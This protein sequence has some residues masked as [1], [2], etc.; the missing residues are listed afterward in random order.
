MTARTAAIVVLM[1]A[2]VILVPVTRA[3]SPAKDELPVSPTTSSVVP[4]AR[5]QTLSAA[6]A[7]ISEAK[8]DKTRTDLFYK[9]LER[10]ER[11]SLRL[12]SRAEGA[13]LA[14]FCADLMERDSCERIRWRAADFLA[15]YP[16]PVAADALL[17]V[18]KRSGSDDSLTR[19]SVCAALVSL[20]DQHVL[21]LLLEDLEVR[22]SP[23]SKAAGDE[24]R[25]NGR[26]LR[27]L[28]DLGDREA[29]APLSRWTKKKHLNS[30]SR[31]QLLQAIRDLRLAAD[32]RIIN[33]FN[34]GDDATATLR[35]NGFVIC[36]AQKNEM[37]EFYDQDYP[38][39]TSD[40]MFHT[41]MILAGATLDELEDLVLI[42]RTAEFVRAAKSACLAQAHAFQDLHLASLA[43]RNAAFLDVPA[44]LLGMAD[45][46]AGDLPQALREDVREE[47]RRIRAHQGQ[48]TSRIFPYVE[49][50]TK[51]SAR[52]RRG[53]SAAWEGYFQAMLYLGRMRYRLSEEEE[54]RQAFLLADAI[55]Q[56]KVLMQEWTD[57]DATLGAFF[58]PHDDLTPPDYLA[59][60]AAVG[61]PAVVGGGP[62]LR[63]LVRNPEMLAAAVDELRRRPAP[64]VNSAFVGSVEAAQTWKVR[65]AGMRVFGQRYTRPIH[66]LQEAVDAG[67]W[68]P[69]GLLVAA[70]LIG[71][72]RARDLLAKGGVRP[73]SR[74]SIPPAV[75][76]DS[77]LTEGMIRCCAALFKPD[78][79]VPP[80]MRQAP[81]EDKQINT[82]LGAWAEVQHAVTLYT[83]D[84]NTYMGCS[85]MTD[86]FHGYVEPVPAFY[87]RLQDLAR[88][89]M[90]LAD[91]CAL[92]EKIAKD[93]ERFLQAFD[94]D[95]SAPAGQAPPGGAGG[96]ANK[97][98]RSMEADIR[99]MER[100]VQRKEAAI[101]L[102]RS[103]Y[104]EFCAIL[105]T[106]QALAEQELR[107]ERQSIDDGIFLKGIGR[108]LV[109]LSFN[110]SGASVARQ[111]MAEI[112]DVATEYQSGQCLEVGNGRPM[113]IYAAIPDSD[114][115]FVCRGAVYMYYEFVR[116]IAE[117][118]DDAR[119]RTDSE[120]VDECAETPWLATRPELGYAWNL[121]R[122][123]LQALAARVGDDGSKTS[124][125]REPW[126]SHRD[127]PG[128]QRLTEG[129]V[130]ADDLDLLISLAE[131][132]GIDLA[133]RGF[134][135][136]RL[137]D[138]GT[139][140]RVLA[141]YGRVLQAARGG[142]PD[143]ALTAARLYYTIIGLGHCGRA[144]LPLLEDAERL[145]S[146]TRQ[147]TREAYTTALREARRLIERHPA[148]YDRWRG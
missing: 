12:Q 94:A 96:S 62:D 100:D 45:S 75:P 52:G 65:E 61:A 120:Y 113:V 53:T 116:P 81:W 49:D 33:P 67:N 38:F 114:R 97:S 9:L 2:G 102:A 71:S 63:A 5:P 41:F 51:Y 85:A 19:V 86:R 84:A 124:G 118:L 128:L 15:R 36:P 147:W 123:D 140:P 112:T 78:P 110:R 72:Q 25:L 64:Q 90:R 50:Y 87:A 16:H 11:R 117:R 134:A 27:A 105:S 46:T 76:G 48:D 54:S 4:P 8:D 59:A 35:H 6:M 37:F 83:K 3:E 40:V 31:E 57:L 23:G 136:K 133:V 119:W 148:G 77:C 122:A 66:L 29:L 111:S 68:P 56:D 106:L 121:S 20:H 139:D 43:E 82:A 73:A 91:S 109:R 79:A 7:E 88:R 125:G 141:C 10:I 18:A 22:Y 95:S 145:T 98:L 1:I 138:F 17:R 21:P 143:N 39:V 127:D 34:L 99:R 104:E 89:L 126:R 108:E 55:G 80:F 24:I 142:A 47:V 135:L 14:R 130:S 137:G 32:D 74:D 28:V 58:G 44:I 60:S 144:A 129:W 70:E 42:P 132:D 146:G 26:V 115:T 103:D 131:A 101:R 107:G 13:E 93:K 30:Q 69:S 92:F